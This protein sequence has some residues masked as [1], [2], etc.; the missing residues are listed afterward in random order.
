MRHARD[1]MLVTGLRAG[2]MAPELL[3]TFAAEV[4][5]VALT[6]DASGGVSEVRVDGDL[7]CRASSRAASRHEGAEAVGAGPCRA[8]P[9][10]RTF[11]R[12][13]NLIRPN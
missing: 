10:I 3:Q 8:C 11:G 7:V 5:S 12:G 13:L 6:P 1:T 4:G 2:W 9:L